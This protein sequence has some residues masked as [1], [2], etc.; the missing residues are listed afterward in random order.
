MHSDGQWWSDKVAEVRKAL[1]CWWPINNTVVLPLESMISGLQ[2]VHSPAEQP[3]LETS[4]SVLT[5]QATGKI[6][7][8]LSVLRV[9][10]I[11][12][13]SFSTLLDFLIKKVKH[14]S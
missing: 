6:E 2:Q 12:I 13:Y 5:T 14:A 3:T 4:H 11:I 7:R 10:F 8:K 9:Y 1:R